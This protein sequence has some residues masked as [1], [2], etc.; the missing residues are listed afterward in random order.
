MLQSFSYVC[1]MFHFG[2]SHLFQHVFDEHEPNTSETDVCLKQNETNVET[3][4][5][6]TDSEC[7]YMSCCA[8]EIADSDD[9]YMSCCDFGE[10]CQEDH[11]TSGHMEWGDHE[12]RTGSGQSDRKCRCDWTFV[13]PCFRM[14]RGF[15]QV[16]DLFNV[17]V[18]FMFYG[19]LS[20]LCS[21]KTFWLKDFNLLYAFI[22]LFCFKTKTLKDRT[23]NGFIS[24]LQLLSC[25]HLQFSF[26]GFWFFLSSWFG[27][28]TGRA[29]RVMD[30][31]S[32][33]QQSTDT[34]FSWLLLILTELCRRFRVNLGNVVIECFE[35]N[36]P[37]PP[38]APHS[39]CPSRCAF[40]DL[41]CS[42][43]SPGHSQH[44]CVNHGR[45]Q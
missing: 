22:M 14:L 23:T 7:D 21:P 2:S 12:G 18:S 36:Y 35:V 33:P 15:P 20:D 27:V 24:C 43:T 37:V 45:N 34:L 25:C 26:R 32:I 10:F 39:T 38:L 6:T 30:R 5:E 44:S 31:A 42:R 40:C 8:S 1:R 19:V 41:Q 13:D 11:G 17:L 29:R 4:D 3:N 28:S 9:D 16:E